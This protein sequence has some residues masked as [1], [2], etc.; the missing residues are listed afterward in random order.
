MPPRTTLFGGSGK[1]SGGAKL[2]KSNSGNL[3]LLT[4]NDFSAGGNLSGSGLVNVGNGGG[5]GGLGTGNLTN[6]TK[7]TFFQNASTT[8]GGNMSGSGSLVSFM[9]AATLTVTGTNTYTGGTTISNGTFQIGNATAGS[10][11]T[12]NITNY[13]TLNIYRSDVFTNK[14][15]I[16]SDGITREYG[17][18]DINLRGVGGMTVDGTAPIGIAGS[19]SVGQSAYG[20]MT[21]NSGGL[22][23]IGGSLLLGN[24]SDAANNGDVIQNGGTITVSNQVRIG[25]WASEISYYTMNGGTLNAPNNQV[26]V[27]W[28]GIGVMTMNGGTINARTFNV[29][30]NGATGAIG[31][32]NSTFTMNGGLLNIGTGGIGGNTATI[33]LGGG[34][35]AATAPAGFHRKQGHDPNQRHR[36]DLRQ[37]Q[38]GDYRFRHPLRHQWICKARHRLSQ[39]QQRQHLHGRG[40]RRQRHPPGHRHQHRPGHRSSRRESIGWRHADCWHAHPE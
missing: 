5:T 7:V 36:H 6:N 12:G 27:G 15:T 10:S 21:V 9:P 39:P 24:P 20:K 8:Y 23:N 22:I 40:D 33:R 34:T 14:N 17:N 31:G 26:G 38:H 28:D 16:T 1:I 37:L 25:H 19:F 29:D 2:M 11:V 30:D 3:T 13:A 35:I 32:T 4:P 18:G